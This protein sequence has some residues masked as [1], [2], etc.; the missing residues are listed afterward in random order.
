[1]T[2]DGHGAATQAGQPDVIDIQDLIAH[3]VRV[4]CVTTARKWKEHRTKIGQALGINDDE[5]LKVRCVDV[6]L[7]D[8][9]RATCRAWWHPKCVESALKPMPQLGH[10]Q[11]R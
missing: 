9:Y 2:V 7:F 3:A 10:R 4:D 1:M 5:K 8:T 11:S 6:N